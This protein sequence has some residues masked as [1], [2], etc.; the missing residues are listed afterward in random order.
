MSD[1]TAPSGST[2][3]EIQALQLE[4]TA[5][6]AGHVLFVS[7]T[8]TQ[9]PGS[10]TIDITT[11]ATP[12]TP[13]SGTLTSSMPVS[14]KITLDSFSGADAG[15]C[16]AS[17]D[18]T[19]TLSSSGAP[20]T[21]EAPAGAQLIAGIDYLLD[22][23]DTSGDFFPDLNEVASFNSVSNGAH[24]VQPALAPEPATPLLLAPALFAL[25]VLL[26]RRFAPVAAS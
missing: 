21:S 8:G 12:T 4:S 26:R 25:G 7:L 13:G 20:W 14:F 2:P 23:T 24:D 6:V 10:M 15:L 16:G 19:A 22:G 18:C 3:I 17:N 9:T 11:P 5:P 1:V